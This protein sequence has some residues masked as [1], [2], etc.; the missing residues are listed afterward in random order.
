MSKIS[1]GNIVTWLTNE[2]TRSICEVE[3][4][5]SV[6]DGAMKGEYCIVRYKYNSENCR[7]TVYLKHVS[8][9]ISAER[10]RKLNQI[11]G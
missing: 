6:P 7:R 11:L 5:F 4:I 1:K 9:N 10:D 3:N 2:G 8:L